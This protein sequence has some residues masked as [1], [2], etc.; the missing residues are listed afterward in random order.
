MGDGVPLLTEALLWVSRSAV[1]RGEGVWIS[2]SDP[3]CFLTA[4]PNST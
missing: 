2:E 4:F 3:N 1:W